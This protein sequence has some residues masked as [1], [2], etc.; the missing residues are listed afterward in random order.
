MEIARGRVADVMNAA[1]FQE[2]AAEY[3][4]EALIDGM[5]APA[6]RFEAYQALETAGMLHVFTATVGGGLVGFISLLVASLPRYGR[7]VAVSE[8]FFVAKQ[9]RKTGAGLR[10]LK[11][12]ENEARALGCPGL[13]VSAPYEGDLSKVLPRVGFKE[14][15]R[16][17]FKR[18]ADG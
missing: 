15:S 3:E 13:L 17:F 7:P 10:L 1:T 5:P 6:A 11:A 2:L 14:S 12:A 16:I 4:A 8:S 18:L 9:Y